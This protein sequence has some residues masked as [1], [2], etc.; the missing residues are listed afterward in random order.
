MAGLFGVP[1]L[2]ISVIVGC[3]VVVVLL[4]GSISSDRE[5]SIASLLE[6]IESNSGEKTAGVLLPNE[7]EVWQVSRELALRL[8]KKDV[9][10]TPAE[11]GSVVRRLT[12]L[13][14]RW[15]NPS[16]ELTDM[17]RQQLHFVMRALALT[18]SPVA[19]ETL[20]ALIADADAETR[21]EALA[22]LASLGGEPTVRSALPLMIVALEDVDPVVRTTA[23]A[24]ISIL[25]AGDPDNDAQQALE[26]RYFDEDREVR[27]NAALALA[28]L[29]NSKGKPLLLDMLDRGYWE[30]QVKV[31]IE[32]AAGVFSE[33]PMPPTAVMRYLMATIDASSHLADE[34]VWTQIRALENDSA[35]AV[36]DAARKV[37]KEHG[38]QALSPRTDE[39]AQS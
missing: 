12:A 10:L 2:I 18:E 37:T 4:F 27:W 20:A 30:D 39:T 28:R 32:T 24:S 25:L 6:V 7:K 21:R 15:S 8:K 35:V 23:C 26:R 38:P 9:E 33:Y 1:L 11:I 31:R 14:Q 3:A 29:G 16:A 19:I 34:E 22:A 5:R 17:G 36:K 13:V